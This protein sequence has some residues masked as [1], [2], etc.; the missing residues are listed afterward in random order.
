MNSYKK[1][2]RPTKG[3]S[4]KK[5][6]I[7]SLKM[8]TEEY[9]TLKGKARSASMN[10]SEFVREAI[11]QSEFKERLTPE[12]NAYIRK[13]TGMANNLNQIARKANAVGYSDARSEY[14]Y[15]AAGID[16]ILK[17]ITP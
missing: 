7:V 17:K 16:L 12:L 4:E 13:L 8:S 6:Y 14:L 10:L 11:N 9:Y 2:G 15:L 5:T 3:I 1:G